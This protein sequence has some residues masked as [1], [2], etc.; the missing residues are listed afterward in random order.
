MVVMVNFWK[1]VHT[2]IARSDIVLIVADARTPESVQDELLYKI[3]KLGKK[4]VIVYNKIDLVQNNALLE[5]KKKAD[6]H[7]IFVS[8]VNHSHTMGLVRKL[9]AIAKGVPSV[10]GVVGFPNTGKSSLINACKGKN[11]AQVGSQAGVTKGMQLLRISRTLTLLDSP[12]VIPTSARGNI[13]LQAKIAARSPN[14]IRDLEG[15]AMELITEF[16]EPLSKKFSI[17]TTDPEEFL[18]K[19]AIN[20]ELK[21][22]GNIPDTKRAAEYL[23][24][25]WQKGNL[26]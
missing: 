14:Q 1:V 12:G 13:A 7:S 18:E 22:K 6:P 25:M 23:I 2:V 17:S 9:N 5:L 20:F 8:A 11:S 24:L 16:M 19:L 21:K 10:V 26:L 4:Y 3:K 15:A